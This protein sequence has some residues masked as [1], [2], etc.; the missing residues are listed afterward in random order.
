MRFD[1][2]YIGQMFFHASSMNTAAV[3]EKKSKTSAF[4][5]HPVTKERA[6][7]PYYARPICEFSGSVEV[8]PFAEQAINAP[9]FQPN[10]LVP[11][12]KYDHE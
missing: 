10:M 8:Q 7:L 12:K 2:L 5:L 11:T 6:K 1:E 3:F 9:A 4:T